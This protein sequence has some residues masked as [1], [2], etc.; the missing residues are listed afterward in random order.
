M[1]TGPYVEWASL[2][3][4]C[5]YIIQNNCMYTA[6]AGLYPYDWKFNVFKNLND[7]FDTDNVRKQTATG[8]S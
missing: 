5:M 1:E 4:V 3:C 8:K 2:S 7:R 6:F